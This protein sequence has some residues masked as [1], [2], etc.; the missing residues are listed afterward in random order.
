MWRGAADGRCIRQVRG[1]EI[2]RQMVI[3]SRGVYES[4]TCSCCCPGEIK[5]RGSIVSKTAI[6]L[7]LKERRGQ[8][9]EEVIRLET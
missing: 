4:K 1:G 6:G 7:V 8:L 3:E 9:P 2:D 5:K